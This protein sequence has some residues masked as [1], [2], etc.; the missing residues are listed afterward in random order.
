VR[1]LD[2]DESLLLLRVLESSIAAGERG[3][4]H[5]TDGYSYYLSPAYDV[6]EQDAGGIYRGKY[7]VDE[8]GS[9]VWVYGRTGGPR[10][11]IQSGDRDLIGLLLTPYRTE[12]EAYRESFEGD[13]RAAQRARDSVVFPPPQ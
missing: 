11:A 10:F 1:L 2:E 12:A 3:L 7:T 8:A 9:G 6:F 4:E 13:A 5:G